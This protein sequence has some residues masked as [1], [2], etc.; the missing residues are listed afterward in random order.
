MPLGLLK[1]S[2]RD[3]GCQC[4]GKAPI[5]WRSQVKPALQG[6]AVGHVAQAH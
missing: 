3:S 4:W 5:T 2:A 6:W 1:W